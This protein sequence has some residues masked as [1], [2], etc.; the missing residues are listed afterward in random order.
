MT[1]ED[2]NKVKE[3]L[4]SIFRIA[5]LR[6]DDYEVSIAL[7]RYGVYKNVIAIYVNEKFEGKWLCE[8]CEERR[9]FCRK[10]EKSLL[11]S[12]QKK[13]LSKLSKKTQKELLMDRKTTFIYYEPYWTSFNSLKKHLIDNNKCIELIEII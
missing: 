8:D 1:K 3:A 4:E 9:R 5:K 11:S 6:I 12:K 10:R 13:N 7:R 2:W